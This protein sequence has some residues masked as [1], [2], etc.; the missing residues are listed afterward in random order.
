MKKHLTI[1]SKWIHFKGCTYE[2]V[3]LCTHSETKEDMVVYKRIKNEV[4]MRL[5]DQP[6]YVRPLS[7]WEESVSVLQYLKYGRVE[8]TISRFTKLV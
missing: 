8:N 6:T 7:M 3:T 2:I 1:G 5:K 4:G